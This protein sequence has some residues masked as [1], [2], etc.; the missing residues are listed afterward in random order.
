MRKPLALFAAAVLSAGAFA[1]L[2]YD[3]A[4][5]G[6]D[7][8][9]KSADLSGSS[10]ARQSGATA[11]GKAS[12]PQGTQRSD[13]ADETGIRQTLKQVTV[14]I[15]KEDGK[16]LSN[17]LASSDRQRL[18]IDASQFK[19]KLDALRKEFKNK[20][21]EDFQPDEMVFGKSYDTLVIVQG[22]VTNP[23]LMSNFPV[24]SGSS[25]SGSGTGT[26]GS[27]GTSPRSDASS[28]STSGGLSGASSASSTDRT[29]SSSAD[30]ASSSSSGAGASNTDRNSSS[31]YGQ[32][33]AGGA[34]SAG[35]QKGF[36][37]AIVTFPPTQNAPE[38][39]V[40]LVRE[41]GTGAGGATGTGSSG[42]GSSTG[43]GSSSGSGSSSSSPRSDASSPSATGAGASADASASSS[44]DRTKTTGV[45]GDQSSAQG[46]SSTS[47]DRSSS[48]GSSTSGRFGGT[49]ATGG[50]EW[51]IKIPDNVSAQQLQQ[52]LAKHIDE[53]TQ[54]KDKWPADK[55]EAYRAIS[56]HIFAAMYDSGSTTGTG[57]GL[58]T[59]AGT[60]TGAKT[61][62][63][64]GTSSDQSK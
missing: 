62:T 41:S 37:V 46:T 25:T 54:M 47:A 13:Q 33:G 3:S 4:A 18:R 14:A 32:S 17:Y 63:G 39:I 48:S 28:S 24:Q 29:S 12:L 21:Q 31:P 11:S 53:V 38:A 57:A 19:D 1:F 36:A 16:N 7:D 49:A 44:A 55:T 50:S 6:K 61:G 26:S 64:A 9:Q 30:R 15:V 45:I 8:Q 2:G 52:N 20:Y 35:I 22:E 43:T 5:F 51:K 23:A 56:Q 59:G 34:A 10:S 27:S 42:S 58:G 40:S 60:G